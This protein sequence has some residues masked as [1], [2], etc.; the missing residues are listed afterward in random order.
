[1]REEPELR[2][3]ETNPPKKGST[4]GV[5]VTAILPFLGMI[6]AC[7]AFALLF[8]EE[9]VR[10][11]EEGGWAPVASLLAF[12]VGAVVLAV[13]MALRARGTRVP[14]AVTWVVACVPWG[15][16]L[17]GE[18]YGFGRVQDAL[19]HATPDMRAMMMARGIAEA[20]SARII[21][22]WLSAA[23]LGTAAVGAAISARSYP[24]AH[25]KAILALPGGLLALVA[26]VAPFAV[27]LMN[28]M[29]IAPGPLLMTLPSLAAIVALPLAFASSGTDDGAR[30]AGS[31]AASA[32]FA[33]FALVLT[34][35]A[36]SG[37]GERMALE[38]V[39]GAAAAERGAMLS[40]GIVEASTSSS[41]GWVAGGAAFLAAAA[42]IG[43]ALT[44]AR[45]KSLLVGGVAFGALVVL[46]LGVDAF[47]RDAMASEMAAENRSPWA[48][49]AGFEPV[50]LH[51][52][53]SDGVSHVYLLTP[54]RLVAP[55]GRG[56]T[57]ERAA[58]AELMGSVGLEAP[59]ADLEEE[60]Y[61]EEERRETGET[62]ELAV[63]RRA[64]AAQ[65]RATL[66]AAIDEGASEL[67]LVAAPPAETERMSEEAAA[68]SPLIGPLLRSESRTVS[69]PLF[70]PVRVED[71]D[72][73]PPP[74]A[75]ILGTLRALSD[76]E[77][78]DPARDPVLRHTRIVGDEMQMQVRPGSPTPAGEIAPGYRWR[79]DGDRHALYVGFGDEVA[80]EVLVRQLRI[81]SVAEGLDALLC[82]AGIPG[83]PGEPLARRPAG[84]LGLGGLG[85]GGLGPGSG[86]GEVGE[87]NGGNVA[88]GNAN[89][90]GSLDRDVIRR[91]IRRHINEVRFCYERELAQAPDL[92][93]RVVVRFIISG[94]GSVASAA[95]A[96]SPL[97]SPAVEGCI[98]QRVQRWTF[99]AP[100]GGGIVSVSYPFVFS[101]Q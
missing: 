1:V 60:W 3:R 35:W 23:L 93:G 42:L 97:R 40:M 94:D 46:Y 61:P 53:D 36:L 65:L 62:F 24:A 2:A 47:A 77:R 6:T 5:V 49:A 54:E 86:G 69:L 55:G 100:D 25:R 38:A 89:V 31:A 26:F 70:T 9:A 57:V 95:V 76:V 52:A 91:V 8:G 43:I 101:S 50:R 67:R 22:L 90:L 64:T 82:P 75:G 48:D 34:G 85:L 79:D 28:Q 88:G 7:L 83:N 74:N 68:R 73:E 80:M 41:A 33:G 63:D 15:I 16:G 27:A 71:P 66:L 92:A 84:G 44:R 58:M 17:A 72:E 13:L 18:R 30:S 21:G 96:S 59:A 4:V 56:V 98:T 87:R 12:L 14:W 39:A 32:V 99:P 51:E 81:A 37:V 19:A 29:P 11:V 78:E 45:E 20:S 10:A